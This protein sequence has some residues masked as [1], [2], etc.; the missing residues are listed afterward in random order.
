[1]LGL[2]ATPTRDDGLTKV[3]E[4][5]LGKPVYWE[6]RRE[7]DPSVIV[8]AIQFKSEDSSYTV[9]PTDYR[10]EVVMARLLTQIVEFE[11]RTRAIVKLCVDVFEE[12]GRRVLVLSERKGHL[13]RMEELLKEAR[14]DLTI[15]YYIGGMK[16]EVREKGGREASILLATYAM[17][18]EAM[19]I[20]SL[21][22]VILASP[23]KKVEQSVGRILRQRPEERVCQPIILDI[24]D[25]HGIYQGQYRKRRVFYKACG[26]KIQSQIYNDGQLTDS[27]ES[28]ESESE[29]PAGNQCGFV[30]DD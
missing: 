16:E 26:Y 13:Q 23:R 22:T 9:E 27:D 18:S 30:D 17:A 21:N 19:N 4:W 20:K 28:S 2:S 1:M 8:K 12:S 14:P 25:S 3:F 6:K 15:G 11:P 29:K 7:A 24:L 5:Y 10:G